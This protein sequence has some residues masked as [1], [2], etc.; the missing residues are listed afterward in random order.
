M[1]AKTALLAFT[2]GGIRPAMLGDTQSDLAET[3]ALVRRVHPGYAVE[4]IGE[5]M[6]FGSEYPPDDVTCATTL[7]GAELLTDRR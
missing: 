2:D 4:P 3:E 1:G 7:A 5:A 6:L